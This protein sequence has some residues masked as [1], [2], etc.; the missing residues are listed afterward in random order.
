MKNRKRISKAVALGTLACC[1]SLFLYGPAKSN[2]FEAW[3]LQYEKNM[4]TLKQKRNSKQTAFS[5]APVSN[6]VYALM[7]LEGLHERKNRKQLQKVLGVN[8]ARVPW[9]GYAVAYAVRKAGGKPVRGYPSAAA[10]KRFGRAVSKQRARK[11]DIAVIR[12]KRGY[13]VTI[14]SHIDGDRLYGI[15]GNQ[16]NSVQLSAFSLRSV[17]SVRR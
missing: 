2:P 6:R 9:C 7:K 8:P 12:T 5:I 1:A 15:G 14:V 4:E 16:G 17:S 3:R 11:G 10:W 13:H